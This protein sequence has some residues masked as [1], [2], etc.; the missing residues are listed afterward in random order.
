MKC[1]KVILG[2]KHTKLKK[3]ETEKLKSEFLIWPYY[4]SAEYI[5]ASELIIVNEIY[6]VLL[7]SIC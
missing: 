3:F 7:N 1:E 6:D 4:L 5:G 2:S